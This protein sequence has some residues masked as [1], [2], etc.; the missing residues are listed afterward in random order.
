MRPISLGQLGSMTDIQRALRDIERASRE[1]IENVADSFSITGTLTETRS[2][3]VDTP[4]LANIAAV[5]GTL[6]SDLKKRGAKRT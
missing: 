4:S 2:L 1:G 6:I 3:N 5:L